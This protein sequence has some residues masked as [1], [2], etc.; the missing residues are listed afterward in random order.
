MILHILIAWRTLWSG[1]IPR[2]LNN[3]DIICPYSKMASIRTLQSQHWH[4]N[5]VMSLLEVF[6][7]IASVQKWNFKGSYKIYKLF[8]F[9][10]A[11]TLFLSS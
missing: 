3:K 4:R 6:L 5:T 1:H 2:I 7:A 11:N 10:V 9:L 8:W